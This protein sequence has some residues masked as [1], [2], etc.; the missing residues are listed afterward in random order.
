MRNIFDVDIDVSPETVKTKY[1]TQAM[2]YNEE[3]AKVLPHPSGVYLE[4]VPV[5]E[6]TGLCAFD[7]E[8]GNDQGVMKV[9]IL[10]NSVYKSFTSK[11]EVL[12]VINGDIDWKMFRKRSV[13]ESLPHLSKH[14]DLV[15]KVSPTSV[16]ELADILALIRPGKDHLIEPYLKDRKRTRN[17]LYRMP[18]T[19]MYFK[20]SHAVSYAMMIICALAAQR[21][22]YGITW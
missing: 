22:Q 16:I 11:Q 18:K 10:N 7:Y 9:D 3:Q 8:Y 2:V 20:K 17:N 12:D 1:G 13:V 6:V 14:F 4:E 5:D 21:T 19:G 15:E